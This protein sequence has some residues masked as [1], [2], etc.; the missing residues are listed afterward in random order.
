M[1]L[2]FACV[3]REA[4][5]LIRLFQN[6]PD[7]NV[8]RR[9]LHLERSGAV[10]RTSDFKSRFESG[11]AVMNHGRVLSFCIA[12]DQAALYNRDDV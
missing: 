5:N 6:E 9:S 1:F 12:P 2:V 11:T 8:I 4:L 10:V 7:T 3:Q